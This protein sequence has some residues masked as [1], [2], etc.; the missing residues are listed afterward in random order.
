MPTQA[1]VV[2][3]EFKL[4]YD[5]QEFKAKKNHA[6]T[7]ATAATAGLPEANSI[8]PEPPTSQNSRLRA[9]HLLESTNARLENIQRSGDCQRAIMQRWKCHNDGCRNQNNLCYVDPWDGKHYSIARVQHEAWA[10]AVA[11]GNAV[12]EQPPDRMYNYLKFEQGSV[13][14]EY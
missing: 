14:Q 9:P 4:E 10:N 13:G 11:A 2:T 5:K 6:A 7:A 3:F 1:I 8:I 12:V